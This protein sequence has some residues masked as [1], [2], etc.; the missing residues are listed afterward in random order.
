MANPFSFLTGPA[1]AKNIFSRAVNLVPLKALVAIAVTLAGVSLAVATYF[2][3]AYFNVGYTPDQPVPFSHDFH[4]G[5][6]GLDCRYCHN[7]VD[8]SAVSNVPSTNTCMNCHKDGVK[9]NSPLLAPVRASAATGEPV[10]WVKVHKAPDY[11][12]FNHSAH[13][14]RGVSCVECHG[15]VDRMEVVGQAKPL[16]MAF[17]LDCHRN[18]E[19]A[20]RPLDKI[21]DLAYA[22]PN[23]AKDGAKLVHDWKINPPQ[24]CSGCH[25]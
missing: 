24:S 1:P 20:V 7:G 17:C 12:Y 13:V 10:R 11:V 23:Q 19:M 21:T 9:T 4:A 2:T 3:P 8:K 5:Q 15:R 18:P 16:S 25:R 22:N 14:N 6:L